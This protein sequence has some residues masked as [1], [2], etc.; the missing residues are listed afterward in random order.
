MTKSTIAHYQLGEKIGEGGMGQVFRATDMKLKREVALKIL[1]D[2]FASDPERMARFSREAQVLASL[3]HPNIASIHGFEEADGQ[4]A[5]VME[6]VDG[7]TIADRLLRGPALQEQGREGDPPNGGL[8][9]GG[10]NSG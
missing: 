3:N 4:R 5:L 7:E 8:T 10:G 2:R 1:P 9:R 6:L